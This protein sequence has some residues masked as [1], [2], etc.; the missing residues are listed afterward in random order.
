MV[1]I[2][3]IPIDTS[4]IMPPTSPSYEKTYGVASIPIP[5][6]FLNMIKPVW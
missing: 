2:F 4:P 5:R 6:K 1:Y 3:S